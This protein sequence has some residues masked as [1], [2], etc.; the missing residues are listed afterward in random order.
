MHECALDLREPIR[1]ETQFPDVELDASLGIAVPKRQLQY[2][3][4]R[5][6]AAAALRAL[7]AESGRV[8]RGHDGLP[9]WPAGFI[10]SISHSDD[11]A[12]A[13]AAFATD[14]RAV[15]FDVE[16]IVSEQRAARIAPLV[17]NDDELARTRSAGL[18]LAAGLTF[19]FSAKETVFKCLF[20]QVRRWFGYSAA[21]IVELDARGGSFSARLSESLS[22]DF[23]ANMMLHGRWAV[24]QKR[25]YTGMFLWRD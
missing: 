4:G 5:F 14:A 6:C 20:P 21:R 10:G 16:R 8:A 25:I 24:G 2:V 22:N 12:C 17:A 23:P 3:A 15:G 19:L 11:F 7:G 1:L 18:D 9:I 13:V